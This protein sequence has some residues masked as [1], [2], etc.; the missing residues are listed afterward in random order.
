MLDANNSSGNSQT[1]S[2]SSNLKAITALYKFAKVSPERVPV[3]KQQIVDFCQANNIYG[4]LLLSCEGING[5]ISSCEDSIKLFKD[6]IQEV[7][8]YGKIAFKDSTAPFIPFKRLKVDIREEI[9]TLNRP[10]IVPLNDNNHHLSPEEWHKVLT[11][12]EDYVLIDTR[13]FY[14]YEIGKFKGAVDPNTLHFS[15]FPKF[16]ESQNYPKDKKIL[17]Y[18]TGG[19]RCEKALVYMQQEGY[20]NVYQLE[21][22][23]LNYIDK[24][25]DKGQWEGECFIFDHRVALDGNLQPTKQYSLCPHCG[26][27]GKEKISCVKCGTSAVICKHCQKTPALNTCSKNCEHHYIRS[28]KSKKKQKTP[29]KF[30]SI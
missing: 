27:P 29:N 17:M 19:I 2:D 9:V 5:T 24:Y 20:Q 1:P 12:Q 22:G 11:S 6:F 4:L 13:N 8:E 23:I 30:P 15:E 7:P 10:D 25:K 26:N 16:V 28:S 18:C 3:I 14:E 21:G